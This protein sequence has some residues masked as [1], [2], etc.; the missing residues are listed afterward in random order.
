MEEPL[1]AIS[2]S[3]APTASDIRAFRDALSRFATGVAVVTAPGADGPDIGMTI[4]SFNSVS[5]DPPLLLFSV[6]RSALS[7]STLLVAKRFGINILSREQEAL[8]SR[9]ARSGGEKWEHCARAPDQ[10][11]APL[12][13]G[14]IAHFECASYANYDGGD[15]VIFVVRVLRFVTPADAEP[16]IFFKGKYRS[17]AEQ[18]AN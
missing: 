6:A 4:S 11:G 8:S 10:H 2:L 13:E 16:L 17:I 7:L 18:P 15:H 5:L 3:R 12:I 9:F 14:A 1:D